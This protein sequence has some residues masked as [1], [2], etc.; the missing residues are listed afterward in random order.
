MKTLSRIVLLATIS[1]FLTACGSANLA[2]NVE[3]NENSEAQNLAKREQARKNL[4]MR[5]TQRQ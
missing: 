1:V 3:K 5:M 4:V 2:T